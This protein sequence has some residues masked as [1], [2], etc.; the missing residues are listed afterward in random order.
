MDKILKLVGVPYIFT[1]ISILSIKIQNAPKNCLF[2]A[3]KLFHQNRARKRTRG[4]DDKKSNRQ[5]FVFE[6]GKLNW[7]PKQL[8]MWLGIPSWNFEVWFVCHQSKCW[9]RIWVI[10]DSEL[11]QQKLW[12]SANNNNKSS[13]MKMIVDTMLLFSLF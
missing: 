7:K 1:K 12:N 9:C 5:F 2:E 10:T 11:F 13:V 3:F 4:K 6:V 8:E